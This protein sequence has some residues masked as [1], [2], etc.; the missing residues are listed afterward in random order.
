[1]DTIIP[2]DAL[3][4]AHAALDHMLSTVTPARNADS[5]WISVMSSVEPLPSEEQRQNLALLL[6]IAL[7]RLSQR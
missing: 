2:V 4:A 3:D 5:I 6:T 7:Q 1:V